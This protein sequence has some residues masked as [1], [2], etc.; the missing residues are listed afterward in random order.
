MRRAIRELGV[1]D[2]GRSKAHGIPFSPQAMSSTPLSGRTRFLTCSA[3]LACVLAVPLAAQARPAR[4]AVVLDRDIPRF[5]PLVTAFQDEVRGFFRPGEITLLPPVAGDGTAAGIAATVNQALQ[6]SSV[7][8]VVTLGSIGSHLLARAGSPPKP[9]IAAIVID[10]TWQD[11]PERNGASGVRNLAYVDQSYPV[12]STLA[13]FHRLIPFRKLAVLLDRDQVEAIP[14][15]EAGAAGLVRAA[16]AEAVIVRAGGSSQEILEALPKDVDAVYL[17]PLSD[18]SDEELARLLA[19]LTHRRLP[20]LSY[21]A[22]PDVR[23]GALA[24]YEP[25]ENWQRRA[26]RVAVDLQRILAGEDAGTLPVRLVSATRLT[27][28]LATARRIGFS[29]GWGVLTEA[30]LVA[31][32]SAGPADTLVLADAMRGAAETNLD[33]AAARLDAASGRQNVR[34]ARSNLL[35]QIESQIGETFTREGTAAASLGQQPERQ[36]NGGITFSM[37]LYADEAW[38]GY[39]SEQRLQQGR[40]ALRDQVRLDVVQDAA[41]AYLTVLRARTL[42][43]VRRSN[44]YATRSNLEVARLREGVGSASR[45]DIYRWQG[46]VANARR[47]LIA[48]DAQ[49]RVA[50]LDLKRLLNR[51]LGRPL[52]QQP[53]SLGDPALLAQDSTILGWLDD[54][55]RLAELTRF[56]VA[57]ALRVS[58]ELVRADATIEAQRRQHTAAGRAFW[59]PMFSLQGGLTNE[60]QRGGA[61]AVAPTFP[62]PTGSVAPDFSWQFRVQASLPLFTGMARSATRAQTRLDLERLEVERDGARLAIEQRVRSAVELAASSHTAI[63]LTRDA[64]EAAGRNYELV[65]DAYARGAASITA[66]IDA[67]SA[68]LSSAESAANAVHDFLLDLV[69]VERAMGTFSILLPADQRQAF[70]ERLRALKERP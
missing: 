7:N 55:A 54:P 22:D 35:P 34:L 18:M 36:L 57:E 60:F 32:D 14:Q 48:A 10:A 5:Q 31:V 50:A 8:I 51:P 65:S 29:P 64:A 49:V 3:V 70:F 20:T 37:P 68:A 69:R 13:D 45:A 4:V 46:E 1:L 26:R 12:G 11:I 43:G 53:V 62:S 19:G 24:S 21:L 6:D 17:T 30:E 25:P 61:G 47:D 59:L 66:L 2:A 33:L 41:T 67:Q 39:G 56:L 52:E 28:N 23:A 16:G 40:E 15:L 42:S 38:A 9:A 58:P 44:L 27:L 63:G